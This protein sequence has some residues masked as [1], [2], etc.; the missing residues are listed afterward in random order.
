MEFPAACEANLNDHPL[1]AN[2]KG[3]KKKAGTAPP[4]NVSSGLLRSGTSSANG[5]H[6]LDLQPGATNRLDLN[7]INT[8]KFHYMVVYLV[9]S[10]SVGDLVDKVRRNKR[11]TKEETI[12]HSECIACVLSCLV[13]KVEHS[14]A[15]SRGSG[16]SSNVRD[17]LAQRPAALCG[18]ANSYPIPA[19]RASPML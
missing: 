14:Q 17:N 11:R 10:K 7:Y 5:K 16:Y 18:H 4:P 15:A 13:L 1:N 6:S 9:E 19:L 8:D 3:I 2:T 12:K